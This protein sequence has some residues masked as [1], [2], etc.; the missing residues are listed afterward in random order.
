[1]IMLLQ[2]AVKGKLMF[3]KVAAHQMPADT[4]EWY[5]EILKAFSE[6]VYYIP[7][8]FQ[9]TVRV[10]NLDENKGY[11]KGSVIV[12]YSG[13]KV[14]YPIIV[15]DYE[16]S[17]FDVFVYNEGDK[18]IYRKSSLAAL[19]QV[20]QSKVLGKPENINRYNNNLTDVKRPGGVIPPEP[21]NVSDYNVLYDE[22]YN[23]LASLWKGTAK[24]EEVEKVANYLISE[25]DLA[26]M[27]HENTGDT[28]TNTI[29]LVREDRVTTDDRE[30]GELDINGVVKAK[31]AKTVLDSQMFNVDSMK[32]AKHGSVAELRLFE[33]PSM[34]DFMERGDGADER[35]AA[36]LTGKP[37]SGIVVNCKEGYEIG[38]SDVYK[39]PYSGDV[40]P[41][42]PEGYNTDSSE[43]LFIALD[44]SCYCRAHNYDHSGVAFYQSKQIEGADAVSKALTVLNNNT[45]NDFS[46]Y[47]PEQ[48]D[49]G[50]DL[51]FLPNERRDQGN[52]KGHSYRYPDTARPTGNGKMVVIYMYNDEP[53]AYEFH[54]DFRRV[55]VNDTW[56]WFNGKCAI[57]TANVKRCQ[58]VKEIKDQMYQMA[59]G[60]PK[61]VF[62]I[63][64]HAIVVNTDCIK[65]VK[66]CDFMMPSKSIQKSYADNGIKTASLQVGNNGYNIVSDALKP[67]EKVAR[68]QCKDLNTSS[69]RTCLQTIGLT[70]EA[71]DEAMKVAVNNAI[72]NSGPVTIY[73]VR[74]DYISTTQYDGLQKTAKVKGMLKEYTDTIKVD[75]VKEASILEDPKAVD[76]VL[77]LNFINEDNVNRYIDNIDG[78]KKL[79][80]D[81]AEM[82]VASRMGLSDVDEGAASKILDSTETVI[83]GLEN[84]K[85]A[86]RD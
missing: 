37:V 68:M 26:S 63:P 11:A 7:K 79:S 75:L 77:G 72:T 28:V 32:P 76:V 12:S 60:K 1:M 23:K 15:K 85:L 82:I 51:I 86:I 46:N 64:E 14:N 31:Q 13:K 57:V 43:Q 83:N 62:L 44:G 9:V 35:V 40:E 73:G 24:K 20:L 5:D 70:K 3:E 39:K 36:T 4:S 16:L 21:V 47:D 6:E 74:D 65:Q 42:E 29:N 33:Y 2:D 80:S 56:A 61:D 10:P 67:L 78:L 17:P 34:E 8:E 53:H 81:M 66:V 22:S 55:K 19:R 50:C 84:L 38:K 18:E 54:G 52:E 41:D 25:P 45:T 58:R 59:I 49:S 69:T 30:E 71:A 48:R 27:Y